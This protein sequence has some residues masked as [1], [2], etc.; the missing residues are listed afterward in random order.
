MAVALPAHKGDVPAE[1]SLVSCNAENVVVD[2]VKKA[3]D[4]A[5]VVV[6]AYEAYDRRTAA[7]KF[8]FGFGVARAVLCDLMENELSELAVDGDT[9]T[10]PVGNFE[11]VTLKI[12]PAN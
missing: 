6:R 5:D 11:L 9:V 4:S 3:E 10:L 1:W 2:T 7:A 12:T 8:R